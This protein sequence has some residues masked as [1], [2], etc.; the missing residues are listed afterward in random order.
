[1]VI[2]ISEKRAMPVPKRVGLVGEILTA[3][4]DNF[5][6]S[7]TVRALS[8]VLGEHYGTCATMLYGLKTDGNLQLVESFGFSEAIQEGYEF[9]GLFEQYPITD[10]IREGKMVR[11]S[12]SEL[13]E[14][15][16]NLWEE[17]PAYEVFYMVPCTSSGSPL[18]GLVVCF[19]TISGAENIPGLVVEALQV[20]AFHVL[21]RQSGLVEVF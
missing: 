5:G 21:S 6:T 11:L 12:A 20:A 9:L 4:L 16:P 7:N 18:G 2:K 19:F 3:A 8:Q 17:P 1:V 15:Y 14:K 10:S 13:S